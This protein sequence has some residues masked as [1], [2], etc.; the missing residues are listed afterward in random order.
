MKKLLRTVLVLLMITA[1]GG[2]LAAGMGIHAPTDTEEFWN[3]A[4]GGVPSE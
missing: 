4:T 1:A 3:A 2:A